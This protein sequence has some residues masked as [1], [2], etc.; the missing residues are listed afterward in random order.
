MIA[1]GMTPAQSLSAAT[2]G[3]AYALGIGDHVG[4]VAA[5]KV[6]DLVD[7][8]RGPARRARAAQPP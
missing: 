5:G 7:V 1:H 2:A 8:R 6:A 3:A 4:T